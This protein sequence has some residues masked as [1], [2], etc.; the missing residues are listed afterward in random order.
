MICFIVAALF[1]ATNPLWF[2]MTAIQKVSWLR[3]VIAKCPKG[4]STT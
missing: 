1:F 2:N 3:P 4:S